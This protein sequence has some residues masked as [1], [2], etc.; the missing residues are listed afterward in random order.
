MPQVAAQ[1]PIWS[2]FPL[3]G[4]GE[5]GG[6]FI[7]SYPYRFSRP[8]RKE[9]GDKEAATRS[10]PMFRLLLGLLA[11]AAR[12]NAKLHVTFALLAVTDSGRGA[13]VVTDCSRL[14]LNDSRQAQAHGMG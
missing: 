1:R 2:C 7:S 8:R 11:L 4:G 14:S 10:T 13:G 5:S 6:E 12:S 3:N 9:D